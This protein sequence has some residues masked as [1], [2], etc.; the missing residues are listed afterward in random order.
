MAHSRSAK[1]R[2]RQTLKRTLRNR[3]RKTRIRTFVRRA[4]EAIAAGDPE[5]ARAAFVKAESELRKGVT[6]GVLHINTAARKISRLARRVKMLSQP[7][8]AGS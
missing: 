1:K 5:A 2:V 3:S 4:E 6:K 8:N 7:E